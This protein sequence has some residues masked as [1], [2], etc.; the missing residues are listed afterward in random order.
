MS[1]RLNTIL[2]ALR[3]YQSA[4]DTWPDMEDEEVLTR[5]EIDELCEELNCG[6]WGRMEL[7]VKACVGIPTKPL[8]DGAL[9]EA[10]AVVVKHAMTPKEGEPCPDDPAYKQSWSD[11]GIE[12][13]LEKLHEMID[14]ARNAFA[15]LHGRIDHDPRD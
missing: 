2:A 3:L 9:T 13:P 11:G 14:E 5:A 1:R 15:N 6:G 12:R 7:C 4:H 8:K 10:L